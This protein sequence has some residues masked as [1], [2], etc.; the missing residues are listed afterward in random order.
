[1]TALYTTDKYET[2]I[3]YKNTHIGQYM[4]VNSFAS[5]HIKTA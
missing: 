2:T 5:W 3:Y 4:H 1:M